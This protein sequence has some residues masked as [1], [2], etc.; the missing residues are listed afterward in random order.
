MAVE[1]T[2]PVVRPGEGVRTLPSSG[3]LGGVLVAAG[4][5]GKSLVEFVLPDR[6][7]GAP[8]PFE[9]SWWAVAGGSETRSDCHPATEVWFVAA[10]AGRLRLGEEDV[11]VRAG[12]AVYIPPDTPHHVLAT[13][14]DE[15]VVF[16][17]WWT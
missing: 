15:L 14:P 2:T 7:G 5:N 16:S 1:I 11:E 9:A 12:Q 8:V 3:P 10:G 6:L 17:V 13:S 4:A